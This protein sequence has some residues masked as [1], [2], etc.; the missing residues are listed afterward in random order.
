M[1][2]KEAPEPSLNSPFTEPT[3]YWSI[4]EH[5]PPARC[6]GRRPAMYSYRPLRGDASADPQGSGTAIEL[7]PVNRIRARL[8]AWRP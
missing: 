6:A 1:S 4:S 5:A 7:K 8:S 2:A 3:H